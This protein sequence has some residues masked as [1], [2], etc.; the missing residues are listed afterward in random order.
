M[1]TDSAS[2]YRGYMRRKLL[3]GSLTVVLLIVGSIYS[4][5]VGAVKM[6]VTDVALAVLGYERGLPTTIIW[7]IRVPRVLTASWR[8]SASPSP[9]PSC[10]RS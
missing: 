5:A 9:G 7:Q 6:P 1:A 2:E 3:L 4:I 10:R 8:V